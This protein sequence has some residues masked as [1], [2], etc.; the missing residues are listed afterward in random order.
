[1]I[2][3]SIQFRVIVGTLIHSG[4]MISLDEILVKYF[5]TKNR[6]SGFILTAGA[7]PIEAC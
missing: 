2:I 3:L 5:E 7:I 4:G 6:R 1:M